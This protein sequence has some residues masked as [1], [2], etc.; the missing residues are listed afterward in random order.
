MLV[1][2][3]A[4]VVVAGVVV[5]VRPGD[6]STTATDQPN[7]V[8][9]MTDD[10]TVESMRVMPRVQELIGG[11]GVTFAD[12]IT[13]F[14][15]CCP[16]RATFLTGQY[17]HNHGVRGNQPPDGGYEAFEDQDTTLPVAL[18]NA[19]YDT[20]HVGKYLNGYG[21]DDPV[22][23]PPG[24][25]E[26]YTELDV[27]AQ[28]YFGFTLLENG[29]E[30]TYGPDDYS[31]DVFTDLATSQIRN[32]A[33]SDDP[34]FLTV[35]YFAPHSDFSLNEG[36]TPATPA[37]R[38][39]GTFDGEPL[40]DS[41]AFDEMDVSDKPQVVQD[42]APLADEVKATLTVNYAKFLES[43]LAVD[44]GVA[45]IVEAL[46]ETGE[47]E[48]TV[49]IFTSDN[50]YLFGEHRIPSG[51]IWFYEPS[52]RV[53]LLVRG[54]GIEAGATRRSL[55]ANIDLAPTILELAGA[56]SLRAM[57]GRS[58]VPLLAKERDQDDRGVLLESTLGGPN[59]LI[60]DYGIR[61]SRYAY[62]ELNTGE[63]ELYDLSVDPDQ[64]ENLA[65]NAEVAEVEA[66]LSAR[67]AK[68]KSCAGADCN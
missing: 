66:D 55:V 40:L 9:I 23:A 10:Q 8:V 26:W 62:F 58:L 42:L 21:W 45:K 43:L 20:V 24:W 36:L 6:S 37:P 19:G 11:Q 60:P 56:S 28:R 44:E 59:G 3:V 27:R 4:L 15:L 5:A 1:G 50:G 63:R 49:I 65:D 18:Q 57:D 2:L 51:K 68:L 54:P 29:K 7:V 67:V 48:N 61:T 25:D 22:D 12:S 14:S 64:L 31:T 35:S 53:P 47:L 39:L 32:R 41:A 46:E 16:S 17:S 33:D 13:S 34:L 30:R 52:I 38:H